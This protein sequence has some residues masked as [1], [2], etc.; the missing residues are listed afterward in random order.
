MKMNEEE[1]LQTCCVERDCT[2]VQ[3]GLSLCTI[4]KEGNEVQS[5]IN[6]VYFVDRQLVF[7]QCSLSIAS[8]AEFQTNPR[9]KDG[10]IEM[11][12]LTELNDTAYSIVYQFDKDNSFYF[13]QDAPLDSDPPLNA[14]YFAKYS[15]PNCV[16][17]PVFTDENARKLYLGDTYNDTGYNF[18]NA[19]AFTDKCVDTLQESYYCVPL[20]ENSAVGFTSTGI[21]I[22][23]N[24]T[25]YLA[26]II[27]QAGD[28]MSDF[29]DCSKS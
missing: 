17:V 18:M 15:L 6:M 10:A 5:G 24:L 2:Y 25:L 27:T 21:E 12:A 14:Y 23:A 8:T 26:D 13:S 7:P 20:S 3:Y 11:E 29:Y 22:E 9:L 28:Y 19:Y 4:F 1:C 16:S